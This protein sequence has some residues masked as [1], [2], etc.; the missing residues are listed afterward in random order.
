MQ[1]FLLVAFCY[2]AERVLKHWIDVA[3]AKVSLLLHTFK[4]N[5]CRG[6]GCMATEVDLCPRREPPQIEVSKLNKGIA[7]AAAAG[8]RPDWLNKNS[9]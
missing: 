7:A 3:E 6:H 1:H 4:Q 5:R 9:F 8:L 2:D